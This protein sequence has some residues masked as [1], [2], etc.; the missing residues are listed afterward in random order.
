MTSLSSHTSRCRA[1]P[2]AV[3]NHRQCQVRAYQH[4]DGFQTVYNPMFVHTDAEASTHNH[5]EQPSVDLT[6]CTPGRAL[7]VLMA[8]VSRLAELMRPCLM[9]S[10]SAAGQDSGRSE[11][12]AAVPAAFISAGVH[13]CRYLTRCKSERLLQHLPSVKFCTADSG[14]KP[15]QE[16]SVKHSH[17]CRVGPR[18]PGEG[19]SSGLVFWGSASGLI[20]KAALPCGLRA[21]QTTASG[22]PRHAFFPCQGG[23]LHLA[24]R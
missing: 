13:S 9:E 11:G 3:H 12:T 7:V 5:A 16:W 20:W 10:D 22:N 8:W 19:S 17:A 23:G 24:L 1:R 15:P 6:A 21:A 4:A 18:R 14:I 2:M